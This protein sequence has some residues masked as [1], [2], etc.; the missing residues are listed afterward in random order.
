MLLPAK[1]GGRKKQVTMDSA[2]QK[3]TTAVSIL[4]ALSFCHLL[5][6]MIQSLLPAIY[7][8][9]KQSFQ[10]S[11][12]QIGLITLV[13][14]VTASLLQPLVGHYTDRRPMPYSLAFGMCFTC[15]GLL[16]LSHASAYVELLGA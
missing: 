15:C 8:I 16:W 4:V 13:N 7:P 2:S 10:L 5:N 12:G 6:D 9:L 3:E 11:F 14:Q 1:N